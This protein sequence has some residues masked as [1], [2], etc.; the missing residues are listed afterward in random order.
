L[1]GLSVSELAQ[2]VLSSI[3]G[4]PG[5]DSQEARKLWL[6]PVSTRGR[7]SHEQPELAKMLHKAIADQKYDHYEVYQKHLANRPVTALR[8][9]DFDAIVRLCL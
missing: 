9:L 1:G 6:C 2:E 4:F 8:D 5:I 7:V 3:S